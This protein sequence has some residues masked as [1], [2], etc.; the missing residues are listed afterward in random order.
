MGI[1]SP[2]LTWNLKRGPLQTTVLFKG[3]L[4]RF[5][6]SLGSVAGESG[7]LLLMAISQMVLPCLAV[8][9]YGL[10]ENVRAISAQ[11]AK[12]SYHFAGD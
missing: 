5:Y 4:I 6:V 11:V 8:C 2:K 3:L 9:I 12:L 7:Q 1:H 10:W